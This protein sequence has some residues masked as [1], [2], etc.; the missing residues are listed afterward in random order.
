[1]HLE[2]LFAGN[3]R[4]LECTPT[5]IH[6]NKKKM[7]LVSLWMHHQGHAHTHKHTH[8]QNVTTFS[9]QSFDLGPLTFPRPIFKDDSIQLM[10]ASPT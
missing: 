3:G 5:K 2:S 10:D 1:M 8:K 9:T 4:P 6:A 7:F